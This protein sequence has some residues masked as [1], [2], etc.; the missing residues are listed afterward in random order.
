MPR[1]YIKK[2]DRRPPPP[3]AVDRGVPQKLTDAILKVLTV[4]EDELTLD[5]TLV[6][7]L[8]ADEMDLVDLALRLNK[9]C[10]SRF[11]DEILDTWPTATLKDVVRTMKRQGATL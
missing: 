5:T 1:T 2:I 11:T 3:R 8:G 9:S 7:D 4:D 10:E 6:G